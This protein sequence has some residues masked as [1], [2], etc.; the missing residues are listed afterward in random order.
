MGLAVAHGIV[1]NYEGAISVETA[2]GRGTTMHVYFPKDEDATLTGKR[3]RTKV[4]KH[5][6]VSPQ[7]HVL[8]V[9]DEPMV[10]D[11]LQGHLARLGYDVT[12]FTN[13]QK[14]CDEF[15]AH[16]DAYDLVITDQSMPRM[17]GAELARRITNHRPEMPVIMISGYSEL[18]SQDSASAYGVAEYIRKPFK[19]DE[20]EQTIARLLNGDRT[21]SVAAC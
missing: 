4:P 6:G 10:V 3:P 14:A 16:P 5:E 19:L 21:Q 20:M 7:G 8:I 13:S 9:D 15:F 11:M 2:S 1:A 17:T 18:V 12:I